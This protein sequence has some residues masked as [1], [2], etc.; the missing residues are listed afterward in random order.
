MMSD[1]NNI[2][3]KLQDNAGDVAREPLE[4]VDKQDDKGWTALHFA[5][6]DGRTD[7]VKA[8]KDKGSDVNKLTK[9]GSTALYL[10]SE[11]GHTET[12]RALIQVGANV[13]KRIINSGLKSTSICRIF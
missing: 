4:D 5:A 10:A 12:V 1:S 2:L 11:N 9:N 6:K 7:R 3:Q 8:L 13:D